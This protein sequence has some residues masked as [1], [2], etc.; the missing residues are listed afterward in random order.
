SAVAQQHGQVFRETRK[1]RRGRFGVHVSMVAT[2][3]ESVQL[4]TQQDSAL[5]PAAIYA[6][7]GLGTAFGIVLL[8]SQ[9][10][11]VPIKGLV[12]WAFIGLCVGGGLAI[13]LDRVLQPKVPPETLDQLHADLKA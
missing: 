13:G 5:G 3:H 4:T 6:L 8:V 2:S 9:R 1:A 11:D 7:M 10:P 12:F